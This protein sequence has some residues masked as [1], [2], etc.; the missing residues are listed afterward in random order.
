MKTKLPTQIVLLA[1][2]AVLTGK[3]TAEDWP[4]WR[5]P[6]G[7]GLSPEKNLPTHW[8]PTENIAWTLDLPP[9]GNSSPVIVGDRIYLTTQTDD[10][11][12]H[13]LAIDEK[14]G[15]L[16]WQ[17]CMGKGKLKTHPLHNMAT[18][19]VVS[20]GE[21]VWALFG[22]GD[23]ACL[24]KDGK[25]LWQRNMQKDHGD[26]HILW[27]M[28][29]SPVLHN[30]MVCVV[31]M[32][33]GPSYVVALDG[34]TGRQ[35]W[36]TNRDFPAEKEG[37]ESYTTPF[38]VG[39]GGDAQ[40]VV[41]GSDHINAYN[42][43]SGVE[44]WRSAGLKVPHPCGRSIS[45]PTY[46]DGIFVAVASGFKSKGH[47][48]AVKAG[49]K[50]DVTATHRLWIHREKSPDCPT[51][52]CYDGLVYVNNDQ[53]IGTC[54]DLKTG[55]VKWQKRVL[56]GDCKVSPIAADG[57]IYFCNNQTACTVIKAG[58]EGDVL[59]QNQLEGKML[60]TPAISDGRIYFRTHDRLYA[61][62]GK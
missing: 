11:S 16:A 4:R 24:D 31:C 45:S 51:P 25:E 20:D 54:L 34:E 27:G 6:G 13:V 23:L 52:V 22:T 28:G 17:R 32:H 60:A 48:M 59:A 3:A 37:R 61:V 12:L 49:G 18:P 19:S 41:C 43:M 10:T 57:K 9:W 55:V 46:A 35:I 14:R 8:S 38:L 56:S 42:P 36:K 29:S 26:Y 44:L 2:I 1:M 58:P 15:A 7:L 53:G 62:G 50:G 30:G 39:T 33:S 40:L 5:G 47:I 21:R